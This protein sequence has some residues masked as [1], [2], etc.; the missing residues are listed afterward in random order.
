M[1]DGVVAIVGRPNVGK[2]SLFNRFIGERVSIVHDEAGVTRDRLYGQS[3][4]LTKD[5]RFIDTGGIQ[6]EGQPFQEEI[7]VQV[8]IAIDEADVIVFLVSTPEGLTHDDQ[9]IATLLRKSKKPVIV[10]A[11]KMDDI[12]FQADIY[13]FYALG[14]GDPIG[15]S[16]EH[17]I[18]IGDL[19]DRIVASLPEQKLKPYE[20]ELRFALIG[21]PNV[22]KS[23]LVNALLNQDR[24]IVSDIEGTTRDAVDT[25]FRFNNKDYVIIDTAGIKKR[26]RIYEDVEKYALL[27]AMAAIERSD[28]VLFLID[29]ESGIRA[30]DKHVAGLAHE[31]GKP[32][33]IVVNKWDV[34]DK[35]ETSLEA[36]R[37]L[38][39][40]EF[41][42]LS[43][44]PIVMV[45][46]LTKKRV[47]TLLPLIDE[48]YA[49]S[50][51]RVSTAVLN[52][53]IQDAVIMTPP[54]SHHGKR[55]KV[56]YASQVAT[57]PPGMVIFV[58]DPE[59]CHF[60][61]KRYLE[62][63]L[64]RA[65]DFSGTPIHIMIRKRGD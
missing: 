59:L 18:G 52:E 63:Q 26:G 5:L 46:A 54:P 55:L 15:V 60:S 9:M 31:M 6:I 65:F 17:G 51:R 14:Y 20:N 37:K 48:V 44:A 53:V 22:G 49:N 57:N 29:G 64:R 1:I 24:V 38:V 23:S 2:S 11:N 7:K 21:R 47:H 34:V 25:P 42:Y 16:C 12:H 61:Y 10:A 41:Q 32:M 27:R 50:S 8:D 28:V 39:E 62:N 58:N 56:Y 36:M 30:Q 45:S 3:Q 40:T 33:V 13:A 35:E 43:Y 19:L 4:W